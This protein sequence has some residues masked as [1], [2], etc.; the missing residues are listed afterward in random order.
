M[1]FFRSSASS[2]RFLSL[3]RRT[4]KY[5]NHSLVFALKHVHKTSYDSYILIRVLQ[6]DLKRLTHRKRVTL[7]LTMCQ[8]VISGSLTLRDMKIRDFRMKF[9]FSKF[10]MEPVML[11]FLTPTEN[12]KREEP[13]RPIYNRGKVL[14]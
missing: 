4:E 5:P 3:S 10:R 9:L 7:L 12:T 1:F 13:E 8:S 14:E 11:G 2:I 6:V